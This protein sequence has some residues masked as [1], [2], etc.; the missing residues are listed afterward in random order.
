MPKE[1]DTQEQLERKKFN[2]KIVASEKPYF[3]KYVYPSLKTKY[4][5]F[6]RNNKYKIIRMF[7]DLGIKSIEDL[8]RYE[9]KTPEMISFLENYYKHLVV[10]DNDCVV[11]RICKLAESEFSCFSKLKSSGLEFDYG[12]LKC[13]VEYSASLYNEIYN[14]YAEY[15]KRLA[16]KQ[17]VIQS[18]KVERNIDF[19]EKA[20]FIDWFK[21]KC[22]EICTNEKELCDILLDICYQTEGTKSFVWE[23]CGD[24]IVQ[25][26]LAKNNYMINYPVESDEECEF[27]FGGRKMALHKKR[28]D[29]D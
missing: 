19:E 1:G 11:N 14:V 4:N 16:K 29:H 10:G 12:I 27:V 23:V 26:L 28:V 20:L 13:G 5:S 22:E 3:M 7:S 15:K 17:N 24:T 18:S 8:E 9:D 25:N 21:K 6:I 2:I